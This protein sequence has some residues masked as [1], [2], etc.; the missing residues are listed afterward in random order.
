MSKEKRKI[1]SDFIEGYLDPKP[2]QF[3]INHQDMKYFFQQTKELLAELEGRYLFK[4]GTRVRMKKD[5]APDEDGSGWRH[6]GHFLKTWNIGVVRE[7]SHINHG[8]IYLLVEWLTQTDQSGISLEKRS[9]FTWSEKNLKL[10][11]EGN[12]EALI[13]KE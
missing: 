7:I 11:D 12:P 2:E 9:K 13:Q 3:P 4:I 10:A 1:T 8:E 5:Y 6:Y